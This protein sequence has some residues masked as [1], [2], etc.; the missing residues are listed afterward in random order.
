MRKLLIAFYT[1]L[2]CFPLEAKEIINLRQLA[3]YLQ[4]N[5][6]TKE[7]YIKNGVYENI[8]LVLTRING[9]KIQAEVAGKVIIS[10]ESNIN[11]RNS[12]DFEFSGFHFRETWSTYLIKLERVTNSKIYNNFFDHTKGNAY[13]RVIGLQGRSTGNL[14]SHN[15]FDGIITMG[16]TIS[17]D[18]NYNNT[19]TKNVFRNIPSVKSVHPLSKDG[20]GMEV[21][22]IG[23]VS[24]WEEP[25]YNRHFNTT[26]SY[27]YFEN[28]EGDNNEVIC[29]K[30]N[31]NTIENNFFTK[32]KGGVSLRFG[33]N[34][35][36][37]D[38]V[39]YQNVQNIIIAGQG[40][41]IEDNKIIDDK[42]GIQI[43]AGH[44]RNSSRRSKKF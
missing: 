26:I 30:A 29:V 18:E 31:S 25:M 11:I 39:F 40:H 44:E 36:V 15:T 32:N 42:M 2:V 27:N 21:I 4:K 28:I 7:V 13:S 22:S 34:N 12:D 9:V 1:V 17:A 8:N 5:P 43:P 37:R 3:V 23:T 10:G 35:V 24:H 14:I 19:I 6:D 16:I 38:N 41:V 20:N 33:S